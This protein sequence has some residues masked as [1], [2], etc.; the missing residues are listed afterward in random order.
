MAPSCRQAALDGTCKWLLAA[1]AIAEEQ[2]LEVSE[3][4]LDLEVDAAAKEMG[5]G[6][7]PTSYRQV[8]G[9]RVLKL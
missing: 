8:D 1:N 7:D 9:F 5:E 3:E 6:F 4:A 2:K